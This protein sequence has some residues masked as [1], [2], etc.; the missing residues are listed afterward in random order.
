MKGLTEERW[1][2][3]WQKAW[4]GKIDGAEEVEGIMERWR[5]GVK[6]MTKGS[7]RVMK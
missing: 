3:E 2:E 1:W 5:G 6:R 7:Y 4:A